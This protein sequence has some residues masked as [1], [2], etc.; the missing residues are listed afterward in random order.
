MSLLHTINSLF[1]IS[2]DIYIYMNTFSAQF[3][4]IISHY[5]EIDYNINVLQRTS[6]FLVNL[7]VVDNYAFLFNCMPAG[8][9][10]DSMTDL[11]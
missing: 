10:S 7:I 11:T 5:K 1:Y 6:C 4:K 2:G 3:I 9:T 8:Q